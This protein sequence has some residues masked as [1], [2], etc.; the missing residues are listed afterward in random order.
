[1]EP[2][3]EGVLGKRSPPPTK[4]VRPCGT[5]YRTGSRAVQKQEAAPFLP[6]HLIARSPLPAAGVFCFYRKIVAKILK[7]AYNIKVME[8]KDFGN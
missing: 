2:L 8:L 7:I 1:M 4:S 6:A 5:E 3:S